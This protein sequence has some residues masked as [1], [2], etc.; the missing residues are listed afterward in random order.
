MLAS[1]RSFALTLATAVAAG[2]FATSCAPTRD[3]S[4]GA[5]VPVTTRLV[6]HKREHLMRAYRGDTVVREF[7]V[8]L[9]RGGL[10]PKVQ[11]GDGRVPEGAYAITGRNPNSAYHL[12][13]RISYPTP[14]Q[15]RA[16]AARGID[17]GGDIFIHGLPNGRGGIGESHRRFDWTEGCIAVTNPEIQWLWRSVPD[18]TPILILP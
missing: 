4:A 14:Q 10:A 18:G 16:A 5:S 1:R 6:V 2:L 13:L 7:K 17:P 3:P 8:A 12:S 9:G 15:V 11:Q